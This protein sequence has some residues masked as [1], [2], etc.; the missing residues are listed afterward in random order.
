M[1]N[2]GDNM[3]GK[4]IK[5]DIMGNEYYVEDGKV[6]VS[7][8]RG[9]VPVYDRDLFFDKEDHHCI[10]VVSHAGASMDF[11]HHVKEEGI[12]R[13]FGNCEIMHFTY[14]NGTFEFVELLSN[15]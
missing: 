10:L 4:D 7:S 9:F 6:Y 1:F 8:Y 3:D 12:G 14:K 2:I 5:K 13:R 11:L 15:D